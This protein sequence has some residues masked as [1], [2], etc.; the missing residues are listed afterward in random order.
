MSPRC[1]LALATVATVSLAFAKGASIYSDWVKQRAIKIPGTEYEILFD[2]RERQPTNPLLA[3]I[4]TWLSTQFN[5]PAIEH[6]PR[7]EIVPSEKIVT[8]RYH[9]LS[10]GQ[11]ENAPNGQWAV[12]SNSDTVA[13]YI[14]STQTI[15][16]AQGWTGSTAADLSILVHEMV[17]HLQN[18]AGLKYECPQEREKLAYMIQD[19][20]LNLFGHDLAR[21]FDLDGFSLLV[22][23]RC[24]L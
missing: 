18:L 5:L 15:Y 20:W 8:L 22:K 17:H 11:S 16:L 21:D 13:I 23:T 7:I 14:D 10:N 3:A 2:K 4:E 6:H 19:R 9:G 1:W 12:S 24:F